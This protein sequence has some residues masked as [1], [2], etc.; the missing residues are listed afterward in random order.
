VNPHPER[1]E[2][3]NHGASLSGSLSMEA[4]RW[5]GKECEEVEKESMKG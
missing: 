2:R 1:D 4:L 3:T 5:K